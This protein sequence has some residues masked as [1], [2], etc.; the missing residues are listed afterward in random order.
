MERW[1]SD[2]LQFARKHKQ[3]QDVMQYIII[4]Y[5]LEGKKSSEVILKLTLGRKVLSQ[6]LTINLPCLLIIV[7]VYST[8]YLKEFF[9]EAVM[10]INLT[11][12]L[13]LTTIF[14][15]VSGDQPTTSYI[16]MVEIWLLFGLFIPFI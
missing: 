11:A 9:F 8:N 5:R 3:E 2:I 16:K 12:M 13:V 6:M 7:V 10:S 1:K 15:G 4:S 14:L